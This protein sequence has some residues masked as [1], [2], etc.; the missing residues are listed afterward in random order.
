MK[1]NSKII[2][3][4]TVLSVIIT[5]LAITIIWT[6]W[7]NVTVGTTRLDIS[8]PKIPDA[9]DGFKIAQISDLHN[10]DFG[11]DNSKIIKIL[12]DEQP[13]LI[14]LTGDLIDSNH[15]DISAVTTFAKQAVK[16]APCYFVTGNH[17]AW[18]GER[19]AE[20]EKML[21]SCGVTVLHNQTV[22]LVW[23]E[24]VIEIAG[25]DDP[26][27]ASS[28]SGMFDLT[29]SIIGTE[30]DN[31]QLSERFSILLSHRPEVFEV[32]A[33]KGIGL[34]LCGHA[35]GGQFRLPFIGGLV[36]PNQGFFPKYDSGIYKQ[37]GTSMVVSRGIGN[38][39]IPIRFNNRPEVVIINLRCR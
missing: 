8:D 14:A 29:D 17:E 25:I 36:A 23:G 13:D 19:Y 21:I 20:L 10:A 16:I 5:L 27:F 24:D 32:Y 18:I 37:S 1:K 7:E 38:S 33:E 6:V 4:R 35:H 12:E 26:E 39:I 9:F 30:I 11:S 3:K 22:R 28:E 31:L 15:T 2:R 34:A